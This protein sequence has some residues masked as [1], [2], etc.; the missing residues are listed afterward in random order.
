[1]VVG[2]MLMSIPANKRR[3][4]VSI[5][6]SGIGPL[7]LSA[8]NAAAMR[9]ISSLP[10][11]RPGVVRRLIPAPCPPSAAR[12]GRWTPITGRA[13]Q[14]LIRQHCGQFR[15]RLGELGLRLS[16]FGRQ[17]PRDQP[18]RRRGLPPPF[19]AGAAGVLRPARNEPPVLCRDSVEPRRAVFANPLHRTAATEA[20]GI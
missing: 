2:A 19:L 7:A 11:E 6:P 8:R 13:V 1:M 3:G 18:G 5:F 20:G 9:S 16:S 17:A 12:C 15:L 14:P 4:T 10:R